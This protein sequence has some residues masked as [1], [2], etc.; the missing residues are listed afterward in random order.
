MAS[1]CH[2]KKSRWKW[3]TTGSN[4]GYCASHGGTKYKIYEKVREKTTL[5][6]LS[7]TIKERRLL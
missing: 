5:Q 2:T 4:D 3:H 6:T 1:I 7:L